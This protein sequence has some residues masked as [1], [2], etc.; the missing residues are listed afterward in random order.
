MSCRVVHGFGQNMWVLPHG[1]HRYRSGVGF[2]NPHQHRTCDGLPMG[3]SHPFPHLM[4][5]CVLPYAC[6]HSSM[7]SDLPSPLLP[8]SLTNLLPRAVLR[9]RPVPS[10]TSLPSH[11]RHLAVPPPTSSPPWAISPPGHLPHAISPVFVSRQ[12]SPAPPP[13]ATP[14]ISPLGCLACTVSSMLSRDGSLE[15]ALS[16][17]P[18]LRHLLCHLPHHLPLGHLARA[19]SSVPSRDSSLEMALSRQPSPTPPP[20]HVSP[21]PVSH[22]HCMRSVAQEEVWVMAASRGP[23]QESCLET[24]H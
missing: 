23:S 18:H 19:V 7:V 1:S 21:W 15:T 5:A 6:L 3:F 12:P 8:L 9:P 10:P 4:W 17:H 20:V 14:S 24:A 22:V 13:A 16:R 2:A 11:L